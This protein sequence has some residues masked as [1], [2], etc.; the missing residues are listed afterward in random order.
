MR[1]RYSKR[2]PYEGCL[3]F[4]STLHYE[5]FGSEDIGTISGKRYKCI[6]FR[7]RSFN[8]QLRTIGNSGEI[9]CTG[10]RERS[11]A[12]LCERNGI[13]FLGESGFHFG[14]C[15]NCELLGSEDIGSVG[16]KCC[17]LVAGCRGGFNRQLGTFQNGVEVS[18]SG[19][20]ERA[21]A[22]FRERN[23]IGF[24]ENGFY[25]GICSN[26]EFLGSEDIRS[27]GGECF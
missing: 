13:G 20:S 3:Y 5:L 23:G 21:F 26:C 7:R 11:F 4:G 14:I 27:V 10:S 12:L 19:S 17:Q 15:R 1:Q 2:L 18:G 25:F 8:R 22:L 6:P 24:S 9:S 16:S